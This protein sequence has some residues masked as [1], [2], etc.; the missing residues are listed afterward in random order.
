MKPTWR[1][2]E[3]AMTWPEAPQPRTRVSRGGRSRTRAQD[4]VAACQVCD[5]YGQIERDGRVRMCRHDGEIVQESAV[6]PQ[7][8]AAP[9]PSPS[10]GNLGDL[11]RSMR[12]PAI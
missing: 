12:Q 4:A 8:S 10:Q 6:L 3:D 9:A 2:L 7:Q 1:I 5:S 11:L